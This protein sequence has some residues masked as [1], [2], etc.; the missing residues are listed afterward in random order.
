MAL[1][2][3]EERICREAGYL[4]GLQ[5]SLGNQGAILQKQGVPD[6]AMALHR[7]E[8]RIAR[9]LGDREA[10]ARSLGNQ[11]VILQDSGRLDEAMALHKEKE[12]ICRELGY[13]PGLQTALNNQAVILQKRGR[14]GEAL[15]LLEEQE[16]ICRKLGDPSGLALSLTNQGVALHAMG[17]VDEG[18]ARVRE[19]RG[20][21]ADHGLAAL[22]EQVESV[23][24]T[25]EPL[26]GPS[27]T[28]W[29]DEERAVRFVTAIQQ[30]SADPDHA[31][32]VLRTTLREAGSPEA[33]TLLAAVEAGDV[34]LS[35]EARPNRARGGID[36][37]FILKSP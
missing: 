29:L 16:R 6:E 35:M 27:V 5:T 20:V 19:G 4:S 18:V 24:R 23:L 32:D 34:N 31:G 15:P 33:M 22:V 2:K 8:E 28:V 3:E 21:A 13:L 9:D 12:Q 30:T 1:H 26:S 37:T 10:I 17:R 7:E 25:V 36:V 11:G 14:G